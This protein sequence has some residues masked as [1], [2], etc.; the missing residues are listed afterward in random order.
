MRWAFWK[1]RK[2]EWIMQ[3]NE[4]GGWGSTTFLFGLVFLA[5][6]GVRSIVHNY[7]PYG[8][9]GLLELEVKGLCSE[10]EKKKNFFCGWRGNGGRFS[11]DLSFNSSL[12]LEISLIHMYQ[13]EETRQGWRR[14]VCNW[15][16]RN[17]EAATVHLHI[18]TP[19]IG[20]YHT[21]QPSHL[22]EWFWW[23]VQGW[24]ERSGNKAKRWPAM[25]DGQEQ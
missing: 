20:T 2:G 7:S 15:A 14:S 10:K 24:R 16:A 21:R 11:L 25:V 8:Y 23:R 22:V 12:K 13:M 19:Y 3:Y 6:W 1:W 5:I 9:T 4:E 18:R 17:S